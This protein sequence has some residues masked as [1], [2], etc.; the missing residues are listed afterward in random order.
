M[1]ISSCA[2]RVPSYRHHKPSGR[3]VVTLN[4]KDYYLGSWNTKSSRREY[5]RL[6]SE[7][8]AAGRPN[9]Q[10]TDSAGG[11]SVAEVLVRFMRYAR[12]YYRTPDGTP[13]SELHNLKLALRPLRE[14]YATTEAA[15]FGPLALQSVRQ[16]MIDRGLVRTNINRHVG[17]IK[18]VF[19]W[20][21]A[22]EL[23]PADVFHGLQ[24]VSG[25]RAGRS[26]AK[27]SDPVKP[28]PEE[29]IDA[30]L[31]LV[32]TPVRA[33]IELQL[34]TGA[35]PGEVLAMRGRELD[36]SGNVWI[37]SPAQH[38][39]AHRGHRRTIYLGP[40][41]QEAVRPFLKDDPEAFLFSPRDS[42][43]A[44]WTARRANRQTPMTP[45]QRRRRRKRNPKRT[46]G[47]CYTLCSYGRAIVKACAKA[48]IPAWHPHQLRHNAAT[49]L[50]KEFGLDVARVILGHRSPVVTEVYAEL[51]RDKAIEVITQVG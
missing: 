42:Q 5:D 6:I 44:Y 8:L 17:R 10:C 47:K 2:L 18:L 32:S 45:S 50:R 39:T 31:P 37:Y 1:S 41:A 29:H 15:G 14:L 51:D 33:M 38:K 35:R 43:E 11:I 4:G 21:V 12:G 28:A 30:I 36:T 48:N 46:P 27:E 16:H 20:A 26:A 7:W 3:A 13:S 23:V 49:R 24:A 25:L 9:V 19:K 22:N 40:R 34:L